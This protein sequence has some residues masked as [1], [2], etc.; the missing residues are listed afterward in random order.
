MKYAVLVDWTMLFPVVLC[1]NE[2]L[3]DGYFLTHQYCDR[4]PVCQ[5]VDSQSF[6]AGVPYRFGEQ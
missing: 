3:V 6:I 2:N 1:C 5:S 4:V